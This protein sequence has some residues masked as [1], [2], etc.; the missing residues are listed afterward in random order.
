[1][2]GGV[3]IISGKL[4]SG[5]SRRIMLPVDRL[6]AQCRDPRNGFGAD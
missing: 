3:T 5:E 1:V 6:V 4:P 2:G